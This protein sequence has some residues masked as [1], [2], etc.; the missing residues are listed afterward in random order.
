MV[1]FAPFFYRKNKKSIKLAT[2]VANFDYKKK[3]GK[4]NKGK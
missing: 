3:K 1:N 4:K 2:T